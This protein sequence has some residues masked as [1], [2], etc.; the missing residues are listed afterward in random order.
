MSQTIPLY[1]DQLSSIGGILKTLDDIVRHQETSE[2][3]MEFPEDFKIRGEE[4]ELLGR[5]VLS[6]DEEYWAFHPATTEEVTRDRELRDEKTA[7]D[8]ARAWAIPRPPV[9]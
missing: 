7:I 9:F 8:N 2:I 3:N 5:A 1:H 4:D 6:D